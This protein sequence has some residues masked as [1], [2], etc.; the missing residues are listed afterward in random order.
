MLYK[1]FGYD[2]DLVDFCFFVTDKKIADAKVEEFEKSLC[3][4]FV[5]EIEVPEGA[6]EVVVSHTTTFEYKFTVDVATG[7]VLSTEEIEDEGSIGHI[8]W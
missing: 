3:T 8:P 6:T 4:S 7:K 1:V 5:Q 2:C